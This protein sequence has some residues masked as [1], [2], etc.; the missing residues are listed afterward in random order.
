MV[1]IVFC[2]GVEGDCT[3]A[4]PGES[5]K[6]SNDMACEYHQYEILILPLIII[7]LRILNAFRFTLKTQRPEITITPAQLFQ[8]LI[9]TSRTPLMEI[10]FNLHSSFSLLQL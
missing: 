9:T 8:P 10:D 2:Y 3:I 6:R 7:Q 1:F 5:E 4:R